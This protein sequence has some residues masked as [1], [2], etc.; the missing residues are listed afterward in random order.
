M[1]DLNFR[2]KLI[3]CCKVFCVVYY[4]VGIFSREKHIH[5]FVLHISSRIEQV[6]RFSVTWL[7]KTSLGQTPFL[8]N[9]VFMQNE[10]KKIKTLR[11]LLRLA[12]YKNVC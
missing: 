6:R 8:V 1:A 9:V 3:A 7:E 12:E 2:S 11:C 5:N 10:K 4:L